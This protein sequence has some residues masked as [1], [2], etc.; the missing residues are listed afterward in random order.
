MTKTAGYD[1][2]RYRPDLEE[3][4]LGLLVHTCGPDRN[5]NAAYLQ[6]KYR[7]NPYLAEDPPP[8][9]V[10]LQD[11][12][13]IGMRGLHGSSW[14]VGA[15]QESIVLPCFGDSY[16][17][18]EHRSFR[19]FRDLTRAAF[20][21]LREQGFLYALNIS[22]RPG[23]FMASRLMG[24]K[25][26]PSYGSWRWDSPRRA[27]LRSA[28]RLAKRL[29]LLAGVA[30]GLRQRS[31]ESRLATAADNNPFRTLDRRAAEGNLDRPGRSGGHISLADEPQPKAM[32]ALLARLGR[33]RA[34]CQRR[35]SDYFTWRMAKPLSA[36]RFL[37]WHGAEL[38]GFLILQTARYADFLE[39]RILD[40]RGS[41]QAVKRDL[42]YA[43]R[44]RGG[45]DDLV[46]WTSSLPEEDRALFRSAGFR[47]MDESSG[48]KGFRRT[49][50]VRSVDDRAPAE[51]WA[52]G[53]LSLLDLANWDIRML[54]SDAY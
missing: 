23:T 28:F 38:E 30:E 18:P 54:D 52:L 41:S 42:L 44:D 43:V 46:V 47:P 8:I 21:H 25:A 27:S 20:S 31:G 34:I 11:G 1:I 45:L 35:D 32:A 29:P 36:Y 22:A 14:N 51:D 16:I 37:F 9:F 48:V 3:Q 53:A 5:L 2:V 50:L 13:A 10:A 15:E 19:L 49:L 26:L 33:E 4:I 6:W 7:T 39:H 24:W 40:L 17:D 12:R